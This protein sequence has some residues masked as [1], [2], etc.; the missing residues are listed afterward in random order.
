MYEFLRRTSFPRIFPLVSFSIISII[1]YVCI[2]FSAECFPFLYIIT[3][4]R[5]IVYDIFSHVSVF[6]NTKTAAI[7]LPGCGGQES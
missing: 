7:P 6:W 1:L 3:S 4:F 5:I 2:S